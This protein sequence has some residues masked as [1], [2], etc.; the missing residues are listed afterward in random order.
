LSIL[1]KIVSFLEKN[2]YMQIRAGSSWNEV[3]PAKIQLD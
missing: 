1:K 2:Q 3:D